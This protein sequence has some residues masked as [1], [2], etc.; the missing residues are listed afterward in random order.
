MSGVNED[1]MKAQRL[2]K[3]M[4]VSYSGY[5]KFVRRERRDLIKKNELKREIRKIFKE[6]NNTY[7]SPRVYA[8]LKRR[9]FKISKT[10]VERLMREMELKSQIRRKYRVITT[11]S[12]YRYKT[13][14]NKL[15]RDFK[16]SRPN[17]KWTADITYIPTK[18]GWCYLAVV[19]DLYSRRI[20]G[21]YFSDSLSSE[22]VIKAV[23][24]A[25]MSRGLVEGTLFHSDRGIQYAC[26]CFKDFLKR[27]KID[28]SMSRVRN[29]WDNAPTESFFHTF[30]VEFVYHQDF[31]TIEEARIK[32]FEWIESYYNRY[33][34]HSSL[35][36]RTP[37]DVEEEYMLKMVA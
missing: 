10:T 21:W 2:C 28:Q 35:G 26:D 1:K 30:K 15:N 4:G 19:E 11:N 12:K 31:E 25:I 7:G 17:E 5:K 27:Y 23:Q 33:R 3:L 22:I 37:V 20:I 14:S 16:A 36:Y 8:E 34:L 29:P 6:S 32:C 13:A 9:G 18:E 24:M